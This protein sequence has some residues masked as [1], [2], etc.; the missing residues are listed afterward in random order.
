M[1]NSEL[2]KKKIEKLARV[3]ECDIST[4]SNHNRVDDYLEF[5]ISLGFDLDAFFNTS[6]EDLDFKK[7]AIE[8]EYL[9]D[10]FKLPKS[11]RTLEAMDH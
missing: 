10:F 5:S 6:V 2:N 8:G 3:L 1:K 7:I 9:D 11:K 4:F